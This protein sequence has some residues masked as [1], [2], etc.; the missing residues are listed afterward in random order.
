MVVAVT[1]AADET[2]RLGAVCQTDGAVVSQQ[3]LIG[4]VPNRRS[5][6]IGMSPHD[7]EQ[8]MLSG[9][10]PDGTGLF[11]APVQ[12][13]P[14]TGSKLEQ[15]PVLIVVDL[16]PREWVRTNHDSDEGPARLVGAATL[17][18]RL[19]RAAVSVRS[20]RALSNQWRPARYWR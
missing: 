5:A 19:A 16:A 4:D 7:E 8:L 18:L 20:M 11:F 10:E 15:R 14:E 6:G 13:G 3:Q 9:R 1:F 12:E 17:F 2:E